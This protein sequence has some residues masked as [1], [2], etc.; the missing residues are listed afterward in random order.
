MSL[1]FVRFFIAFLLPMNIEYVIEAYQDQGNMGLTGVFISI[2]NCRNLVW[3]SI[4]LWFTLKYFGYSLIGF[5]FVLMTL[6]KYF[7][8]LRNWKNI[9]YE[10]VYIH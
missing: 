7:L 8:V 2:R 1:L 10:N 4:L 9:I 3:G 5:I 6:Y